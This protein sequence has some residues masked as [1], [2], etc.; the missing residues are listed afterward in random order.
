MTEL[1][2]AEQARIPVPPHGRWFTGLDSQKLMLNVYH[3][4]GGLA[5]SWDNG[6]GGKLFGVYPTLSQKDFMHL[7]LD[8]PLADRNGYEMLVEDVACRAYVDVEWQGPPDP[9]HSTL[10]R[11]VSAIRSKV[12]ETYTL[13]PK[14][15]VCCGTRPTQDDPD[16]MKHSYHIVLKNVIFERNN[17][18]QM[19]AFFTTISGFTWMDGAEEK[20]MIDGR[21]YTKNRHFRLP[22]CCKIGSRVPLLRISGDPLL[23][24]FNF[25]YGRDVPAV[26]SFFISNPVS[27]GEFVLVPTPAP[28]LQL[29]PSTKG[30]GTKRARTD[31]MP[32][33]ERVFPVP[34]QVVQR[35]LQLAGDG[36]ST[37]GSPQY[38]PEE[39]KWKIQCDQRGQ[40]RKCLLDP[41]KT[42]DSNNVLLF[43]ER[44]ESGFR[45]EYQCMS[46][47]CASHIKPIL[48][49]ISINVQ[50]VEWQ[51]ALS[52][53]PSDTIH[54]NGEEM[55]ETTNPVQGPQPP[56]WAHDSDQEMQDAPTAYPEIPVIDP[57]VDVKNP[58]L[59]DYDQVK[60]RFEQSCAKIHNPHTYV[61]IRPNGKYT[62]C[63]QTNLIQYFSNLFYFQ[64]SDK[65]DEPPEKRLFVTKWI[66]DEDMRVCEEVVF[67]PTL[68]SGLHSNFNLWTGFTAADLPAVGPENVADL[69]KPIVKHIHDVITN[70]VQEHTDW[71][72]DYMA[73]MLQR[74]N[75]PTRVAISLYGL[76]GA[77][78][79]II[80]EWFRLHVLGKHCTF[81]TARPEHDLVGQ[82]ANGVVNKILVQVDEVKSLHDYSDK[83]KDLITNLTVNYEKKGKDTIELNSLANFIFTSNNA[84][85][86][87]VPADDRRFVLFNCSSQYK[88]NAEYFLALGAHLEREDVSRA[89]YQHLMSRDLTKYPK[90]FQNS[91]PITEY[92]REV[93]HNCIPVASRFFS[94]LV[95]SSYPETQIAAREMYKQYVQFHTAGNYRFLLTETAFGCD[96]KR[97]TGIV[98]KR[99]KTSILYM[100]DHA[101]IKNYLEDMNEY[102]PDA[103]YLP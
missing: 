50:T 44:F 2:P 101:I 82:F 53:T 13:Q 48:G 65:T 86:L 32:V 24:E 83:I 29:I 87:T 68:P 92:Y 7:L 99:T 73:S 20:S 60:T 85:A 35:L 96:I 103:E 28:L 37:V 21:V 41:T 80:F 34:I 93:Q 63:N 12:L 22:H 47:E 76:Q 46:S 62:F 88:H 72:L 10:Q 66:K 55:L 31:T 9:D 74:P 27:T 43:I 54:D 8:I 94:A 57:P 52:N 18:G 3:E 89:F 70:G 30:N 75:T 100:L 59:N 61:V 56:T 79:G 26:L 95:N 6:H 58:D 16:V 1:S 78:K 33:S 39:D 4:D 71:M 15:Y 69:I 11:L 45:V 5:M 90:S 102:D 17:D 40:G 23:D 84:K 98:K 49:Y 67:D 42:H 77:G 97:V 38:L 25:D 19:K 36:K 81:Q 14:I 51:I 91:R 64:P